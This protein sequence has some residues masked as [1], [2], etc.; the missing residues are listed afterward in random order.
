M[1]DLERKLFGLSILPMSQLTF[2]R[3]ELLILPVEDV[4]VKAAMAILER[5]ASMGSLNPVDA[6]TVAA[7]DLNLGK[8]HDY[9]NIRILL[10]LLTILGKFVRNIFFAQ[11]LKF[12]Q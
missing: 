10:Q 8:L 6:C 9:N 11:H 5:S 4:A 3:R 2:I 12:R 7:I 1:P